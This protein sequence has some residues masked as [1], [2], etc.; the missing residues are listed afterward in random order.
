MLAPALPNIVGTFCGEMASD[1]DENKYTGALK[2]LIDQRID[3]AEGGGADRL[4]D[5]N[6]ARCSPVYKDYC[7]TVQP[8][9]I[10][11]IQQIKY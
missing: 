11:L 8:P 2:L 4:A 10:Q 6:A 5:F 3:G 9:T 1:S 7:E